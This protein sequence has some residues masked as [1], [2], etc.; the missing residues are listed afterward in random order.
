MKKAVIRLSALIMLLFFSACG[1]V[2]NLDT[3]EPV[4]LEKDQMY[5]RYKLTEVACEKPTQFKVGD[6]ICIECCV[7]RVPPWPKPTKKGV[8]HYCP[9]EIT[10]KVAD[11]NGCTIK[12]KRLGDLLNPECKECDPKE[13]K[14]VF[15]CPIQKN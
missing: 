13:T 2:K 4:A 5:C 14:A 8:N 12:A 6:I 10:F 3:L 9:E 7:E 11:G 1:N 15:K